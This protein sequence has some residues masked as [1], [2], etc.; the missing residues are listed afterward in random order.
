[1]VSFVLGWDVKNWETTAFL[2]NSCAMPL[3]LDAD[4]RNVYAYSC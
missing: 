4:L 2:T 1:M 3:L